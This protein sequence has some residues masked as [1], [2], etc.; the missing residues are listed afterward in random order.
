VNGLSHPQTPDSEKFPRSPD[1]T[2]PTA[3]SKEAVFASGTLVAGLSEVFLATSLGRKFD[4]SFKWFGIVSAAF[5]F[6]GVCWFLLTIVVWLWQFLPRWGFKPRHHTNADHTLSEADTL[7]ER[8]LRERVSIRRA[9]AQFEGNWV[10]D[11]G[12]FC[13]VSHRTRARGRGAAGAAAVK[14][15]HP[16]R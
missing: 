5:L 1:T 15:T 12:F 16:T 4:E 13:D 7:A 9:G 11:N 8:R 14:L 10:V 2:R 6:A 3:P